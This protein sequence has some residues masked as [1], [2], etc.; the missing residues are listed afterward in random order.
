MRWLF[1][2]MDKGYPHPCWFRRFSLSRGELRN[3]FATRSPAR[4]ARPAVGGARQRHSTVVRAGVL[5]A[6]PRRA[7]EVRRY[8]AEEVPTK[9]M[10]GRGIVGVGASSAARG[11]PPGVP[12][13]T[14]IAD[15]GVLVRPGFSVGARQMHGRAV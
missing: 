6:T 4:P 14:A 10:V 8:R 1:C 13:T 7:A 15:S 2:E 5:Q 9:T 12:P 3:L 11:K